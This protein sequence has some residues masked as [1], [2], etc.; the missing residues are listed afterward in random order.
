M[1]SMTKLSARLAKLEARA[2]QAVPPIFRYGWVTPLPEDYIG[3]RHVVIVKREQGESPN[4]E[5]CEFEER[6][7]LGPEVDADGSFTVL[8]TR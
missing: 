5:W 2:E 7:G 8:L 3:D 4:I 6:P 1:R